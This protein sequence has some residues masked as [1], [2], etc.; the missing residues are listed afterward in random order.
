MGFSRQECWSGLPFPSPGG[1]PD[2]GIKPGSP[3]LQE[4]ALPSEPPGKPSLDMNPLS[5]M[6]FAKMFSQKLLE[7][8]WLGLQVSTAGGTVSIPGQG[9]KI[10][11]A[12]WCSR[13]KKKRTIKKIFSHSMD[14]LCTPWIVFWYTKVFNFDEFP[15]LFFLL[16]PVLL[17]SCPGNHC[18]IQ[19]HE[20]SKSFIVLALIFRCLIYW[21]LISVYG[22]R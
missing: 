22:I 12:P 2:P 20:A 16:L 21:R 7:V 5:N 6:L 9:T 8:Q 10:S 4:D 19:C 11:C 1:L 17:M 18:Q 14:C 13:K 3:T 15:N